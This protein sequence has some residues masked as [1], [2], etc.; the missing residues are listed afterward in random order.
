VIYNRRYPPLITHAEQTDISIA[1]ASDLVGA[2]QVVG[3]AAPITG[4]EDFSFMLEAKPGGF[5]MIGNGFAPDGSFHN[6]HTPGYDFND[7]ILTLGAAYWVKLVQTELSA[8]T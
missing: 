4:S 6:V 2:E 1:A 7:D 3:N 8:G 5:I